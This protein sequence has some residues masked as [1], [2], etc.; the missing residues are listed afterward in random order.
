MIVVDRDQVGL[1]LDIGLRNVQGHLHATAH[2]GDRCTYARA[3]SRDAALL[4]VGDDSTA[5]DLERA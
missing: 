3:A 5:T 4:F 1:A 2:I